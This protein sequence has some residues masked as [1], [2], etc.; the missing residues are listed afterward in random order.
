MDDRAAVLEL[1][2]R[3][4]EAYRRRDTAA[5]ETVFAHDWVGLVP[6]GATAIPREEMLRRAVTNPPATL[7]FEGEET[8]LFGDTAVTTGHLTIETADGTRRQ[9][10]LRVYAKREGQW[11]AVVAQVIPP[12]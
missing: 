11:R 5:L 9:R 7:I 4:N 8:R 2:E 12:A 1:N 3:W 6:D 10:Y